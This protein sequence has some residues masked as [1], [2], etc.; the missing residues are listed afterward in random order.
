MLLPIVVRPPV[1]SPPE[2]SPPEPVNMSQAE[3]QAVMGNP[4][5][6]DTDRHLKN[7][8]HLYYLNKAHL[9]VFAARLP[10]GSLVKIDGHT[11][12]RLWSLR[13]QK[14]PPYVKA[15]IYNVA[16]MEEAEELYSFHD[17]KAAVEDTKDDMSGAF[18]MVEFKP[19]SPLL[20]AYRGSTAIKRSALI[21]MGYNPSAELISIF[22]AVPLWLPELRTLDQM[23]G[24]RD[25]KQSH[26]IAF[27]LT[28]RRRGKPAAEAWRRFFNN[29]GMKYNKEM[30]GVQALHELAN[31]G[32]GKTRDEVVNIAGR[33]VQ[34]IERAINTERVKNIPSTISLVVYCN[35]MPKEQKKF[36]VV[37]AHLQEERARMQAS[38]QDA[39]RLI[40][41]SST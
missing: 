13:P 40:L 5:Q 1:L 25:L 10:D 39:R 31:K 6:R 9:V 26:L 33:A 34:C 35:K 36:L 24:P 2:L 27:L 7:S 14:A 41:R 30:D 28:V 18:R 21:M 16:S 12:A 20:S 11:R 19:V 22:D 29:E 15:M 38:K 32:G 3:W 37:K 8:S 4:R 17:N 23:D